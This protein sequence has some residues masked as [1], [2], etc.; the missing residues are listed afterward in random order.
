MPSRQRLIAP[1]IYENHSRSCA[2]VGHGRRRC[3]CS[4]SYTALITTT[5][6]DGKKS[7]TRRTV[8]TLVEAQDALKSVQMLQ[9]RGIRASELTLRRFLEEFNARLEDGSARQRGG[10]AFKPRSIVIYRQ[11]IRTVLASDHQTLDLAVDTISAR[12]MQALVDWLV[13]QYAPRTV[14][15]YLMP[16]RVVWDEI[17]RETGLQSPMSSVRLPT[18]ERV[19]EQILDPEE[20]FALIRELSPFDRMVCSLAMQTGARS[21]E[22][23]ALRWM[24]VD[25]TQQV[26]HIHRNFSGRTLTTPK[27]EAGNRRVT[28]G[29]TLAREFADYSAWVSENRPAT[30][31]EDEALVCGSAPDPHS[32]FEVTSFY[33]RLEKQVGPDGA[34]ILRLHRLRKIYTSVLFSEGVDMKS[35]QR[36]LGHSSAALTIGT[37]ARLLN[38]RNP[39]VGQAMD[40]ALGR[41]AA[42]PAK[43]EA[44]AEAWEVWQA[45]LDQENWEDEIATDEYVSSLFAMHEAHGEPL[46][47]PIPVFKPS[48]CPDFRYLRAPGPAPRR[49]ASSAAR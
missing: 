34:K 44:E 2:S 38:E 3:S 27:S 24:D 32:P 18:A 29:D 46:P 25:L 22:I 6:A 48:E 20:A 1:N 41:Y 11:G 39:I 7:Q 4:P 19:P 30:Y 40:A 31:L 26:I 37:Y 5:G 36:A 12:E 8:P 23:R 28:F 14:A 49:R 33:R 16:V 43:A 13:P 47:D 9:R 15:S 45:A 10:R 17:Q 42:W 21:G 35:A